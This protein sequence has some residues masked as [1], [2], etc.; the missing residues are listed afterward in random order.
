MPRAFPGDSAP[1]FYLVY[2]LTLRSNAPF[3]HLP[4]SSHESYDV[5]VDLAGEMSFEE[6]PAGAVVH[7][8]GAAVVIEADGGRVVRYR[9]PREGNAVQLHFNRDGSRVRV[10]WK[11]GVVVDGIPA[12]VMGPLLG[13]CI[14][15]RGVVLLHS[16]AVVVDAGAVLLMGAPGAGKSTTTA[17]LMKR[18]HPVLTE[19]IA[20]LDP[21]DEGVWVQPGPRRIRLLTDVALALGATLSDW[22]PLL[23]D[24]PSNS[25][26]QL[27]DS[28]G[29]FQ[30]EP[31]RATMLCFLERTMEGSPRPALVPLSVKETVPRL[32]QNL[33]IRGRPDRELS[34]RA[35]RTCVRLANTCRSFAV[36]GA[37]R[38]EDLNELADLI[39]SAASAAS[40]GSVAPGETA[41]RPG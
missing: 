29:L 28:G 9:N 8:D 14:R 16:G 27:L 2:G 18:G 35:F 23:S 7:P 36:R 25:A 34:S 19:D 15:L 39:A 1:L 24:V 26:K 11:A 20:A 40:A 17:A 33:F 41:A 30:G 22:P 13:T 3:P 10:V 12:A 6:L 5:D 21:R 38:L 32:L 31:V 4:V 37:L